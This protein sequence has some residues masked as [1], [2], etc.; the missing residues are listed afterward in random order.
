MNESEI[1]P[2]IGAKFA[3]VISYSRDV[4]EAPFYWNSSSKT[5]C[6]EYFTASPAHISFIPRASDLIEK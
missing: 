1:C 3:Y 2:Q 5:K 4:L 6:W